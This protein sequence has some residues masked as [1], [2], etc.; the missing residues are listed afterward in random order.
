MVGIILASHGDFAKGILQS[1]EMIFGTQ[2]NVKAVT[3]Q[4][5][6]G[7]DDIRAKMEEAI[8]TFE[9]PE[10]V[11]FM[12]DL[13]GGTPFNQTSGLINGHEDTWA[14]VTGL[15]L[16]MLIEAFASRMSMESAQEI[17]AHVYGVAKEGV[18]LLPEALEPAQEKQAAEPVTPQG[19]IPEGTV[20]GDGHI[21][22]VLAR[23][24]SRLLHGQVATAWTKTV[25]PTRIIVVSDGVAKDELRKNLIEQAAPPGVKANVVPVDKMIQVAKDPRFGNTKAML[26]FETPQDALRAIEG[27]VDVKELNIGS[28]AHSVGKIAVSKVLSLGRDDVKTF[29]KLKAKGIQFDVRKVPNDSKENMD[30]IIKKAKAELA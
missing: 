21:K 16:P 24:D 27:G 15:N 6:E 3:L 18:R 11:L 7:P 23:I 20:I 1:G 9:N 10:Q 26:L 19:A 30:D 4:P 25:K 8:T 12:V 13:W 14:V 22:Y 2:P 28:M 17:A 5:S 29:E